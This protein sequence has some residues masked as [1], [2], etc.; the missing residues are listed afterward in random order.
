MWGV[1]VRCTWAPDL[2]GANHLYKDRVLQATLTFCLPLDH[3]KSQ[4]LSRTHRHVHGRRRQRTVVSVSPRPLERLRA[5]PLRE[6]RQLAHLTLRRLGLHRRLP[7]RRD[8]GGGRRRSHRRGG[9]RGRRRRRRRRGG[10]SRGRRHLHRL[11]DG[12]GRRGRRS[13]DVVDVGDSGGREGQCGLGGGGDLVHVLRL[14]HAGLKLLHHLR[15]VR[16]HAEHRL[17]GLLQHEEQLVRAELDR[18]LQDEVARVVGGDAHAVRGAQQGGDEVRLGLLAAPV[19]NE[20]RLDDVRAVLVER[21]RAHVAGDHSGGGV[22]KRR[23]QLEALRDQVVAGR[24]QDE[25]GQ[26][27]LAGLEDG[28]AVDAALHGGLEVLLQLGALAA[29][30]DD[31]RQVAGG[32]RKLVVQLRLLPVGASAGSSG[33]QRRAVAVRRVRRGVHGA[34]EGARHGAQRRGGHGGHQRRHGLR[35]LV[36]EARQL[37][38]LVG[39]RRGQDVECVVRH[40]LPVDGRLIK[41]GGNTRHRADL[42]QPQ[43]PA[44]VLL[45]LGEGGALAHLHPHRAAAGVHDVDVV[46]LL[47]LL[48]L[49]LRRRLRLLLLLD[50]V[51]LRGVVAVRHVRSAL[52]VHVLLR[53]RLLLRHLLALDVLRQREGRRV[54]VLGRHVSVRVVAHLAARSGGNAVLEARHLLCV[55]V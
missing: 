31:L 21:K 19:A 51:L 33:A 7:R 40:A 44:G 55:Y 49:L 20:D 35:G 36:V 14:G 46:H 23:A 16:R 42:S 18:L 1:L 50:R 38:R 15:A 32:R 34:G 39:G 54:H 3:L 8:G 53:L 41:H 6:R 47:R 27:A 25:L 22:G 26:H 17:H 10:R 48:L 52:H 29:L 13:V 12:G 24:V 5:Q 28:G 30:R 43:L 37:L 4:R 2:V 45:N 9:S 11:R